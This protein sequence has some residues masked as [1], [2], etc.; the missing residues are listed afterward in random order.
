MGTLA[1]TRFETRRVSNKRIRKKD[2]R[3]KLRTGPVAVTFM[4]VILVCVSALLYLTQANKLATRG[5]E[6]SELQ[7][8]SALLEVE[9]ERLQVEAVRLQAIS[10]VEKKV[11]DDKNKGAWE[12]VKQVNYL[13]KPKTDV[14]MGD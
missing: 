2:F 3:S 6:M 7:Q 13:G 11:Q 12:D 5:Y 10:E 9:N 1:I 4:I 14:A 8:Q